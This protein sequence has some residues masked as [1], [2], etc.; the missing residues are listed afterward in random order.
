MMTAIL[1]EAAASSARLADEIGAIL[2]HGPNVFRGYL[3]RHNRTLGRDRR[4][5]W[6]NTGD[7]GRQDADGYF[8]LTGRRKELIIRGGHNIDPKVIEEALQAHPAVAMVAAIGSPDAYAGEVPVVYVQAKPGASDRTG[9]ARFAAGRIPERA[10]VPKHAR[11]VP[12]LPLTNVGKIFKPAL[13]QREAESVIRSEADAAGAAIAGIE[14]E[15]DSAHRPTLPD[16]RRLRRRLPAP[17]AGAIRLQVRNLGVWRVEGPSMMKREVVMSL[18]PGGG[19]ELREAPRRRPTPDEIEVVV[20]AA[21]VNPID[22]RRA[23][24]LRATAALLDGSRS[25]SADAGQ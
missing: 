25:L 4:R 8:W 10:A 13:Q 11:I 1:D 14:I 18:G 3:D 2:I 19:F 22:V 23:D 15:Q 7:L 12:A 5:R 24:G 17:G 9:I 21:S 20:E 6:L 16:P